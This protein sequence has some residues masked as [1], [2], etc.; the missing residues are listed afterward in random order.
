M[1]V[2]YCHPELDD[3]PLLGLD[4]HR[5]FYMLRGM[6]QYMV[7]IGKP[8]LYQV[9]SSLNRFGEWPRESQLDLVVRFFWV[10]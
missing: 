1:L 7:A 9:V 5:M 10:C 8:E 6:L 3:I 4:N 2:T